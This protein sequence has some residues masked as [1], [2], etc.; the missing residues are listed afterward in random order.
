MIELSCEIFSEVVQLI[1]QSLLE[2]LVIAYDAG[3]MR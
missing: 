2:P 1:G 3:D